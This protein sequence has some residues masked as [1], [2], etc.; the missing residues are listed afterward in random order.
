[1]DNIQ[2]D[3][4]ISELTIYRKPLRNMPLTFG[5]TKINIGDID[6]VLYYR[7]N[8]RL[9]L[10]FSFALFCLQI[11]MCT[12]ELVFNFTFPL[13]ISMMVW[14]ATLILFILY[15]AAPGFAVAVF[16]NDGR[17]LVVDVAKT[18][19]YV[20]ERV[21][22]AVGKLN[23]QARLGMTIQS[24]K[25]T[26]AEK[27]RAILINGKC[28]IKTGAFFDSATLNTQ[29]TPTHSTII[30]NKKRFNPVPIIFIV[31]GIILLLLVAVIGSKLGDCVF[32]Q[33]T[34]SAAAFLPLFLLTAMGLTMFIALYVFFSLSLIVIGLVFIGRI[35]T[36]IL[37]INLS[38]NFTLRCRL[39]ARDFSLVEILLHNIRQSMPTATPG[40]EYFSPTDCSVEKDYPDKR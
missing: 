38:N 18:Q 9:L 28:S 31:V 23:G 4:S 22:S 27:G 11:V 3:E 20:A 29:I 14:A 30:T 26:I 40:K 7:V 36:T 35:H 5:G 2:F 10:Y 17:S 16:K 39:R 6:N 15:F 33:I 37:K 24:K 8:R 1:M 34:D 25:V 19:L 32:G 12:V 21:A 13:I